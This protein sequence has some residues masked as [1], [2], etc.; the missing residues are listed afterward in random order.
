MA[1]ISVVVPVYNVE[2]YL[3][4]CL[5]S[6]RD[7]TMKSLQIICVNDGSTDSSLEILRKHARI[8]TRILIVDK[9]N[10][11]LS[12]ARNAGL[13]RATGDYVCFVD[14]DDWLEPT[15]CAKIEAAFRNTNADVVT[16]GANCYPEFYSIPW[17]DDVLSPR[18]AVYDA[19]DLDILFKEKSRPYAWRTAVRTSF[20]KREGIKFDETVKFG[21]DQV[22]HFAVY[23][24]A[25]RVAF[26]SDKLYN[27]RLEREGS[28]MNQYGKNLLSKYLQHIC[29]AEH[30]VADWKAGGLFEQYRQALFCW[31]ADFLVTLPKDIPTIQRAYLLSRIATFWRTYFADE[32]VSAADEK[33]PEKTLVEYTLAK[34]AAFDAAH[35]ELATLD[36]DAFLAGD[37]TEDSAADQ[38]KFKLL[39]TD[40]YNSLG[41]LGER[42]RLR[43]RAKSALKRVLKPALKVKRAAQ[44][45]AAARK[46]A[47]D[48]ATYTQ[49]Y[50]PEGCEFE[51]EIVPPATAP[52][53]PE[54][55][56]DR[57]KRADSAMLATARRRL[58]RDLAAKDAAR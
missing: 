43:T 12:S 39:I 52:T 9:P 38:L 30:I 55:E 1:I 19:F 29:I 14:S 44:A 34:A 24:R 27:Y 41:T 5:Y 8:D 7:Q 32:L 56:L 58:E 51:G 47:H 45:R 48:A 35:P 6:L 10:G 2:K 20:A 23:P 22:F 11:G 13:A 21:E 25:A 4:V 40:Y 16:Y 49:L 50:M 15:A 31:T 33:W 28:L 36:E 46:A 17:L 57:W 37:H 18:D 42:L 54:T 3:S 26:I 53:K